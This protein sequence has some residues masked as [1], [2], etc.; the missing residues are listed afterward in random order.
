MELNKWQEKRIEAK[1]SEFS[2][3]EGNAEH[4]RRATKQEEKERENR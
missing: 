3:K 4:G 2:G 1:T